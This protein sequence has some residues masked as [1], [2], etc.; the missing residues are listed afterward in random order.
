MD[1][2]E[3]FHYCDLEAAQGILERRCL[4][5]TDIRFLNDAS[6]FELAREN[7]LGARNQ[8][9]EALSTNPIYGAVQQFFDDLELHQFQQS[10]FR[11]FTAC[12][13]EDEDDISLWR[14][15]GKN[16]EG[17]NIGF[18]QRGLQR[19]VN[20]DNTLTLIQVKYGMGQFL[21]EFRQLLDSCALKMRDHL[22][23]PEGY[24]V[25]LKSFLIESFIDLALSFKHESF[26]SEK[27]WRLV[28]CKPVSAG[29]GAVPDHRYRASS[30]YIIPYVEIELDGSADA[31]IVSLCAGPKRYRHVALEGLQE[32]VLG[33][34]LKDRYTSL[35]LKASA[36][37][38]RSF[39]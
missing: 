26:A 33:K 30:N 6:E 11:V 34:K 5:A 35:K 17:Y 3:L 18:D 22:P 16:G 10:S 32:Y 7:A 20:K 2:G 8:V 38:F 36:I 23:L 19:L 24:E 29:S 21:D 28:A 4:W 37:P 25:L 1:T 31:L 27:E 12:F 13:C 9:L 39:G 14:T 15:Y